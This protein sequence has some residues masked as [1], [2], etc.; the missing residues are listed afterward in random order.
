MSKG[1]YIGGST[2]LYISSKCSSEIEYIG[3]SPEFFFHCEICKLKF[4]YIKYFEHLKNEHNLKGCIACGHPYE[5]TG[6]EK[7]ICQKCGKFIRLKK[8]KKQK[9]IQNLK[10]KVV[11]NKNLDKSEV[12]KKN[13]TKI[14]INLKNTNKKANNTFGLS[15]K[16]LI[17]RAMAEKENT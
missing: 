12:L 5:D 13:D 17:M 6:E 8:L 2:I 11:S 3:N 10:K 15:I 14:D 1:G 7:H 16:D 9:N 4:S